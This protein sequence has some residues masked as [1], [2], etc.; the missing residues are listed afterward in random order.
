[1]RSGRGQG[2]T[3]AALTPPDRA[4]PGDVRRQ[5][6]RERGRQRD[7]RIRRQAAPRRAGPDGYGNRV[8]A[9]PAVLEGASKGSGSNGQGEAAHNG[10][11]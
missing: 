8:P 3:D 10:D 2:R 6:A 1:M 7:L 5:A 9:V 4:A 11:N